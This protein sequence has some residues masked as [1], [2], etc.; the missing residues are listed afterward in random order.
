MAIGGLCQQLL[1]V[2]LHCPSG[3]INQLNDGGVDKSL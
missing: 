1:V 3:T 2:G